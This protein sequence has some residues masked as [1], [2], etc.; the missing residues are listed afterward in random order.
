ME[1]HH[2]D[3]FAPIDIDHM[4]ERVAGGNETEVYRSDDHRFVVKL[5]GEAGSRDAAKM[6]AAARQMQHAAQRF[7][8][9]L[10]TRHTIPT[11][12]VL[13][14]D[15]EGFVHALA[16]Q[17]YLANARVLAEIDWSTISS[18]TRRQIGHDL[19]HIIGRAIGCLLRTGH[20]P[21]LY[22]R[23]SANAAERQRRKQLRYLPERIWSFL[24]QR[25]ILH[26]QNLMLT[27][28][29]PPRLVLIDYD[30]V[31][32][33]LLYRLVYFLARLT[34]FGRDLLVIWWQLE[35]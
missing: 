12:F 6:L 32:R 25:T 13:S 16:I 22:G 11:Y 28:E 15:S 8:A 27:A 19:R 26:S 4:M 20:L 9:C 18:A 31:R 14:R 17:P 23:I 2:N 30:E 10:G 34:L 24:A 21:D 5:K 33:H 35:R 29:Q 3:V 1:Q 7:A